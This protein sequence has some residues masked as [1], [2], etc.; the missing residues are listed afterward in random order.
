MEPAGREDRSLNHGEEDQS[1]FRVGKM[2]HFG[3]LLVNMQPGACYYAV[4]PAF[5]FRI[6]ELA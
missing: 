2:F 3:R 1:K 6:A 5:L 4:K